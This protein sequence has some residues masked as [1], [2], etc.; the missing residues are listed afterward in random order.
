MKKT[1]ILLLIIMCMPSVSF[2]AQIFGSLRSNSASVGPNV[3]VRIQCDDGNAYE[4]R[5]DAYGSYSVPLRISKKCD[6]TVYFSGQWSRAFAVY[7]YDDPVRYD[8]DLVG[9]GDGTFGLRRR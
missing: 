4:A 1:A 5:T 9:M 8:F 3:P 2:G 7:P 6:L